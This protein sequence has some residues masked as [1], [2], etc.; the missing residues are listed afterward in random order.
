MFEDERS[1]KNSTWV[2][3]LKRSKTLF[4]ELDAVSGVANDS[5]GWHTSFDRYFDNLS[6]RLCHGMSLAC[7]TEDHSKCITEDQ[8]DEVFR[9]GQF[10]YSHTYRDT[11]ISL[12]ASSRV[13]ASGLESWRSTFATTLLVRTMRLSTVTMW[14]T[15]EASRDCSPSYK[16]M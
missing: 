8:A 14:L 5:E 16:S 1:N 3:H 6:A 13:T 11:P 7:N 12:A 10:E 4:D 9:L 15:M 2:A